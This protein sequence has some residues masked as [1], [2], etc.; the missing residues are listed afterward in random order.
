MGIDPYLLSTSLIGVM[1]QRLVRKLCP[2]CKVES[3]L[4][5]EDIELFEAYGVAVPRTVFEAIGC[6]KCGHTGYRG[7]TAVHEMLQVTPPVAQAIADRKPV[8]VI[9]G[10]SEK[11]GYISLAKSVLEMVL[12]GR[13]SLTE[14]KKVV[15][16]DK[17]YAKRTT[18]EIRHLHAA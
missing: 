7:R 1:A 4:P 17:D 5:K 12:S 11:Y 10:L 8:D 15:F 9:C 6:P 3:V 14:A 16:L 13:I 18:V 2:D